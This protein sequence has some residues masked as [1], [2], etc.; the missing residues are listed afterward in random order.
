MHVRATDVK[1]S[2]FEVAQISKGLRHRPRSVVLEIKWSI[3][4]RL[5]HLNQSDEPVAAIQMEN[6]VH[7][8]TENL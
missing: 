6:V 7:Y 8:P 1:V 3:L 4:F 5:E 2:R